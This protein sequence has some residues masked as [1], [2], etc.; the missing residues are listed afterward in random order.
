MN[1]MVDFRLWAQ[2]EE[3]RIMNDMNDLGSY[4]F[5]PLDVVNHLGLWMTLMTLGCE[6]SV[7]DTM[8]TLGLWLTS[9]TLGCKLR[10]LD[11]MKDLGVWMR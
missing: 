11:I 9:M 1:H 3:L 6:V 2:N 4:Q 10:A 8:N 5:K 7:L